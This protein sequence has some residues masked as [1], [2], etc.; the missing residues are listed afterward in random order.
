MSV[1]QPDGTK[2][3]SLSEESY[4]GLNSTLKNFYQRTKCAAIILSDE[5]GL[6]VARQGNMETNNLPVLSA[7]AAA[8]FAATTEMA[9]LIGESQSFKMHF[10]EGQTNNIYITGINPEFFLV[11]IF[12]KNTTFGM[13]R[14]LVE[15]ACDELRDLLAAAKQ[16]TDTQPAARFV[17]QSLGDNEFQS[18]LSERLDNLLGG[19]KATNGSSH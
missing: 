10:H 5:S 13:V 9:K 16:N 12:G 18:E 17:Q 1:L 14:V 8:D 19:G 3:I 2:Q 6:L 11:V 4:A 15:K 7:L